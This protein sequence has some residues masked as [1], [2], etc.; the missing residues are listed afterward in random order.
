MYLVSYS[1]KNRKTKSKNLGHGRA[2]LD[3]RSKRN[4][5]NKIIQIPKILLI[6][7]QIGSYLFQIN[8]TLKSVSSFQLKCRYEGFY[9]KLEGP[10]IFSNK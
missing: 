2:I 5:G 10:I 8:D 1:I 4:F 6:L 9:Y 7:K 3:G